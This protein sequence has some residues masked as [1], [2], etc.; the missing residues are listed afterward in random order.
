M[1]FKEV[2]TGDEGFF[3]TKFK[4]LCNAFPLPYEKLATP[5]AP[6]DIFNFW[7]SAK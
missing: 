2:H 6:S 1:S 7:R 3:D 4:A 5:P